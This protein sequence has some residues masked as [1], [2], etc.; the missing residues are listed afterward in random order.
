MSKVQSPKASRHLASRRQH[1]RR[2]RTSNIEHPTSNI[3]PEG[4]GS[5][6]PSALEAKSAMEAL[7][8]K[9]IS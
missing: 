4:E 9:E 2:Y 3:E 1:P 7:Q 8:T 5:A 6:T